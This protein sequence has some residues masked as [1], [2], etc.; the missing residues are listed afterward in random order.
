MNQR[1][2]TFFLVGIALSLSLTACGQPAEEA[3]DNHGTG[4]ADLKSTPRIALQMKP[5]VLD[6]IIVPAKDFRWQVGLDIK[7]HGV[8][9]RCGGTFISRSHVL[10]AAHCVDMDS[11]GRFSRLA[12][13]SNAYFVSYEAITGWHADDVYGQGDRLSF[14]AVIPHEEWRRT[15]APF[16]FDVAILTLATP[17]DNVA[18]PLRTEGSD[19]ASPYAWVSGWGA[20]GE[21]NAPSKKLGAHDL[22]LAGREQ[23]QRYF[24]DDLT[25]TQ[26]MLC[27]LDRNSVACSGDSGGPL[28]IGS[29]QNTQ[30]IGVVS[31]GYRMCG[32][33]RRPQGQPNG[34]VRYVG[35]FTR[36]SAIAEWVKQKTGSAALTTNAPPEPLFGMGG[37]I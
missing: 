28:V 21:N 13:G 1:R 6:P 20:I 33:K 30:L 22:S 34:E 24:G 26:D 15:Q 35:M 12:Q 14:T 36:S 9:K 27:T 37:K 7:M 17:V 19:T 23:C 10:T 4:A 3:G 18:I 11:T 8:S 2:L 16:A 31:A 5:D 29:L 32:E 25:I